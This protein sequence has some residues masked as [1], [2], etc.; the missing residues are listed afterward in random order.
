MPKLGK[1][2]SGC[3][4]ISVFYGLDEK[5]S[6]IRKAEGGRGER[7]AIL[8]VENE[9]QNNASSLKNRFLGP[10]EKTNLEAVNAD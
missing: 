6:R 7:P 1:E 2:N 4:I 3:L 10:I 9:Q 8:T 5:S